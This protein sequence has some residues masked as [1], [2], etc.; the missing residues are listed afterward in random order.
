MLET[1]K[2]AWRHAFHNFIE[3]KMSI[4]N[5]KNIAVIFI[6]QAFLNI[7][8]TNATVWLKRYN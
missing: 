2:C 5:P 4:K 8:K 1:I 6:D 3:I 7:A